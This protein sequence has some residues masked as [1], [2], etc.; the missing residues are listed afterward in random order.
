MKSIYDILQTLKTDLSDDIPALLETACLDDFDV[1]TIGGSRNPKEK[2]LCVYKDTVRKD[3]LQNILSLI[4][5]AQLTGVDEITGA[6]YEDVLIDYFKSYNPE[7]IE[8]HILDTMESGTFP[9][10]QS[11]GMIILMTI[12]FTEMLDGCDD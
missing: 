3:A 9:I 10:D 1:Y 7:Y 8:M 2:A 12:Q 5:Q 4:V 6:K 11:Q